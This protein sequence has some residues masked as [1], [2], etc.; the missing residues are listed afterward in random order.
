MGKSGQNSKNSSIDK[1][2]ARMNNWYSERIYG[3]RPIIPIEFS[4]LIFFILFLCDMLIIITSSSN[5]REKTILN[6]L[7]PLCRRDNILYFFTAS[8]EY[9]EQY[10]LL[11]DEICNF[12]SQRMYCALLNICLFLRENTF[13]FTL[14]RWVHMYAGN[15]GSGALVRIL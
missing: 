14:Y 13:D 11:Y 4:T 2:E 8:P 10:Y 1:I 12:V 15:K 3:L 7:W 5:V 6:L 9:Q